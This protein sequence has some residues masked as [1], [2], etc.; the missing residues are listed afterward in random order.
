MVRP[1]TYSAKKGGLAGLPPPALDEA[2]EMDLRDK[3][4]KMK[5]KQPTHPAP[6]TNT[7]G[8]CLS[9]CQSSRTP[10]NWKLPSTMTRPNHPQ[11][12]EELGLFILIYLF[13]Y[14]I[15]TIFKEEYTISY[16]SQST[17]WSSYQTVSVSATV[18]GFSKINGR[19]FT[20]NEKYKLEEP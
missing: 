14:F 9:I 2:L 4:K 12:Q 10:C 3:K 18:A 6:A 5:K 8:P 16:N 1:I 11:K 17:L 13:I 15:Y 19:R 20:L 7:A